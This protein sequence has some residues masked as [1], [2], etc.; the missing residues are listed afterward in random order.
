MVKVGKVYQEYDMHIYFIVFLP[1]AAS[2]SLWEQI[3]NRS[4]LFQ[5]DLTPKMKKACCMVAL[6]KE[7]EL[8]LVSWCGSVVVVRYDVVWINYF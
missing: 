1:Q 5:H 3:W 4:S 8:V 7:Y 6:M 2:L